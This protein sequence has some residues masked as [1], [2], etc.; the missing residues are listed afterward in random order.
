MHRSYLFA[1]GHNAKLLRRVFESDADAVILDLE[2]AVPPGAK[3]QARAMVAAVLA[4]RPAWVRIN[5]VRTDLAAADLDA[6][7]GLAAGIRIPKTESPDD[8]QWVHD[9]APSVPLICAIESA[10]GL[11]A[12]PEIATAPGVRHLSMGGVDLRRDLR[13]GDGVEVGGGEVGAYRVD[14]HPCGPV[15]ENAGGHRAGPMLGVGRD[16]V[17]QVEYHRVGVGLEHAA[18]Q[19]GVVAR[20]EQVA[21]V[22]QIAPSARSSAIRAG[23]RPSCPP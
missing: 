15:S 1:P 5:T 13:A 11:L 23:S 4:E 12:A 17:F 18:Q 10:R 21:A 14:P 19:L 8:V 20:G 16:G 7:A 6:V 3:Q 2:D 22:H 9:R